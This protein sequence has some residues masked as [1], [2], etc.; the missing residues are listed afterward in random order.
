MSAARSPRRSPRAAPGTEPGWGPI[1]ALGVAQIA[2]WGVVYYVFSVVQMPLREELGWTTAQTS[3]AFSLA[4]LVSAVCGMAIGRWLDRHDARPVLIGGPVA[5][6]ALVIGW[7]RVESL[8]AFYVVW[9][10][11][12]VAMACTLY[13]P[14][15]ILVAK[16]WRAR[17]D[18]ALT[19]ITMMGGLSSFVYLPLAERLTATLGWR[20]ALVVLAGT[21]AATAI[22]LNALA[23]RDRADSAP[24]R[25]AATSAV[26]RE[27][28]RTP[29]FWALAAAFAVDALTWTAIGVHLIPALRAD[30]HSAPFAALAAGL[31]G[32]CQLPG[33]AGLLLISRAIAPAA[34]PAVTLAFGAVAAAILAVTDGAVAVLVGVACFGA[35]HGMATLVR[36]IV[37]ADLYGPRRYGTIASTAAM[38]ATLSQAAGPILAAALL[39]LAGQYDRVLLAFGLLSAFAAVLAFAAR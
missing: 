14:V 20:N 21:L 10:G 30:G 16:R 36:P 19:A 11:M 23:L 37:L 32:F 8:A 39:G 27:V 6:A 2:C 7:S 12:G 33:R 34:L 4:L 28:L 3:G 25:T 38:L 1:A 5:A 18:R 24:A 31:A 15:F 9:I 17:R 22:P 13:E 29:S 26:P 35:A